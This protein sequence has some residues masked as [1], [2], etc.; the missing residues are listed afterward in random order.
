MSTTINNDF[1]RLVKIM[2]ELREKCPWD[3]KQTVETLRQLTI[4][5]TFELADAITDKDWEGIREELGDLLLHI[6]FYARIA[7]EEQ[8]FTLQEVIEGIC[9]KL[10]K[11]HPHIYSDVKVE[12]ED[13]VKRNWENL[14]L[15]EGKKSVLSGVPRSLPSTVKAMRLQEKARQVGF[16]WHTKEAV[17]EKILEEQQE[18]LN[19]VEKAN[20]LHIEEEIGDVLFSIINYARFVNVDAENALELTNKKF[21]HRFSRMEEMALS[22]QRE[23][24]E[25]SLEEM[26]R[27]WN[28]IKNQ[29]K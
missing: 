13:E 10:V 19:A 8:K 21:I 7:A 27:L 4:E 3:R 6:I 12:N 2:D 14:K 15:Q 20:Q 29:N 23:L 5:E 24:S 22:N 17:W 18:L 1:G 16:E 26:D 28:T 25:M 9:E 11:R